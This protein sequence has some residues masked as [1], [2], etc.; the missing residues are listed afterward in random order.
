MGSI[1]VDIGCG[2]GRYMSSDNKIL[3]IGLDRSVGLL[4]QAVSYDSKRHAM[5]GS[6]LELPYRNEC[7]DAAMSIAVIHHFATTA[8]R[9]AA[10]REAARIVRSGGRLLFTAWAWEQEKFKN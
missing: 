3:H 6:G 1:L 7:A 10:I 4:E 9:V 5:L 2:N 8:R